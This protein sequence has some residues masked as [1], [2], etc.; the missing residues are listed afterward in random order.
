MSTCG[1][2][3]MLSTLNNIGSVIFLLDEGR[4]KFFFSSKRCCFVLMQ[5]KRQEDP[6]REFGPRILYEQI[7][8]GGRQA[9]TFK[10]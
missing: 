4:I 2:Y 8:G 1:L 5:W 7:A 3:L 9:P 10:V 6:Y